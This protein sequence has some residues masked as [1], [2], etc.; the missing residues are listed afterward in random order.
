MATL[1]ILEEINEI[2]QTNVDEKQVIRAISEVISK[3]EI[4]RQFELPSQLSEEVLSLLMSHKDIFDINPEVKEQFV[5]WYYREEI[6]KSGNSVS[7]NLL[8]ELFREYKST[9]SI[10]L[11]SVVI[12]AI[13]SDVLTDSQIEEARSCFFSKAFEKEVF[14]YIIRKKINLCTL[15]D[16]TDVNKLLDL[17]LYLVLE[18]ALDNNIVSFEGLNCIIEPSEGA[19]D[20]KMRVRLFQKARKNRLKY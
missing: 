14:A 11:E 18:K 6:N 7:T 12:Q 20:K 16:D 4:G 9:Q 13:K 8:N 1:S 15:L 3:L 10:G 5:W 2:V 19:P 17:R